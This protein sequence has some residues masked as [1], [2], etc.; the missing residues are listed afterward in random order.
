MTDWIFIIIV[1]LSGTAPCP[2]AD[3]GGGSSADNELGNK[4]TVTADVMAYLMMLE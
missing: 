2:A 1:I 4:A 3:N